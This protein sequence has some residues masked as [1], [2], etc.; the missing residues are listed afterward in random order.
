MNN[1]T[2]DPRP[3][4][5]TPPEM[6]N[7]NE[8]PISN[9]APT[10]NPPLRNGTPYGAP[11][12]APMNNGMPHG[13]P[14]GTPMNNGMPYGAPSGTP[15]NNGMPYGAP[16]QP[17]QP[18]KKK[19]PI[20]LFIALG[21]VL[22]LAVIII[23]AVAFINYIRP[24]WDYEEAYDLMYGGSYYAALDKFASLYYE[25]DYSDYPVVELAY[26]LQYTTWSD[27]SYHSLENVDFDSISY[28][29]TDEKEMFYYKYPFL[30]DVMELN[31]TW[32]YSGLGIDLEDGESY[33]TAFDEGHFKYRINNGKV[34]YTSNT[35]SGYTFNYH[36][37][38]KYDS[39]DSEYVLYIDDETP[40][41]TNHQCIYYSDD[42]DDVIYIDDTN[43]YYSW[44]L[45]FE[46]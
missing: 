43:S 16:Y 25:D 4:E 1:N 7:V 38:L 10:Y 22:L 12:G 21:A 11:N 23:S 37:Y 19:P 29:S 3:T 14:N 36:F 27:G 42:S 39:T 13:A 32:S 20:A 26:D 9:E 24:K 28:M 8:A 40:T 17:A 33:I 44:L 15:M 46:R 31:G 30:E 45:M 35:G 2:F 18:Q 41:T 34:T 5:Q 6:P